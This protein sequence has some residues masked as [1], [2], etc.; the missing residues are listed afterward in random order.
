MQRPETSQDADSTC[1]PRL[2]TCGAEKNRL[3]AGKNARSVP[4]KS[5]KA[6][7]RLSP[8][9]RFRPKSSATKDTAIA[10]AAT[11]GVE[12]PQPVPKGLE[13]I[14]VLPRLARWRIWDA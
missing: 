4:F 8:F 10:D 14:L 13:F 11:W 5:L 12:V 2:F 3:F 6:Q 1:L 7:K 9:Y